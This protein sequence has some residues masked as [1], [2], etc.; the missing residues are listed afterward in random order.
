[1]RM[2]NEI[3]FVHIRYSTEG[4]LITDTKAH[5]YTKSVASNYGGITIAVKPD[6]SE[7]GVTTF[8]VGYSKTNT[9]SP[10][11]TPDN[12]CRKEGRKWATK[13]LE[14]ENSNQRFVMSMSKPI[15]AIDIREV[16]QMAKEL[17][18]NQQ[19]GPNQWVFE[20]TPLR[21]VTLPNISFNQVIDSSDVSD[22]DSD[23]ERVYERAEKTAKEPYDSDDD[24][25]SDDF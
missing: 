16:T 10:V 22:A 8:I 4:N 7:N 12:F 23:S 2:S 13:H 15:A 6:K 25:S 1:M 24:V 3:L 11:T 5:D 20:D 17:V 18:L 14:N 21:D 9:G 19:V